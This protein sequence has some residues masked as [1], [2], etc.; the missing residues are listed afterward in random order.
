MKLICVLLLMVVLKLANART[1]I[2]FDISKATKKLN[3]LPKIIEEESINAANEL[4]EKGAQVAR[5]ALDSAVTDWGSIRFGNS[6]GRNETGRMLS[7]LRALKTRK[8]SDGTM[9]AQVGWYFF[10]KYFQYQELGTG[11]YNT[12]GERFNP[13]WNYDAAYAA[14]SGRSPK[15][16]IVGARSLWTARAYMQRNLNKH[17]GD[18]KKNVLKRSK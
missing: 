14:V 13:N 10:T 15:G 12:R 11:S 9:R 1:G 17:K 5:F 2:S 16:G 7:M 8:N 4:A 18:I 6:P 3:A